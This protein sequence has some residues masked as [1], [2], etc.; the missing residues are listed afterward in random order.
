MAH[1]LDQFPPARKLFGFNLVKT[2]LMDR[3]NLFLQQ[4]PVCASVLHAGT[5]SGS[6]EFP[7]SGNAYATYGHLHVIKKG[8]Y[9]LRPHEQKAITIDEPTIVYLPN[10]MQHELASIGNSEIREVLCATVQLG[11]I[12]HTQIT[13]SLPDIMLLPMGEVSALEHT[14]SLMFNEANS[15]QNGKQIAQD[16]LVEYFLVLLLRA[17]IDRDDVNIGMLAGLADKRLA[18]TIVAVQENPGDDWS[19]TRM[20]STAGMSRSRFAEHFKNII[21][22]TPHQYVT[23]WR[24]AVV[25]KRLT[26]GEN[27]NHFAEELGYSHSTALV[28]AFQQQTGLTPASWL[29]QNVH[30]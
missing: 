24:V 23:N 14:I 17:L 9:L 6:H 22:I 7:I 16:S 29:K 28:R 2:V 19:L 3:L 18:K 4:Y 10:S 21:G 13:Q 1:E 27:F 5:L 15:D 30:P 12:A 8:H 26:K 20:A 11:D 25:Q